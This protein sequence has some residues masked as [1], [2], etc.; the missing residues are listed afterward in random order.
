MSGRSSEA[1]TSTSN[2]TLSAMAFVDP[3]LWPQP[4]VERGACRTPVLY[5]ALAPCFFILARG[6]GIGGQSLPDSGQW[7]TQ[8]IHL[9]TPPPVS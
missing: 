6:A 3:H 1:P 7:S 9:G 5:E 2:K 4:L 8:D